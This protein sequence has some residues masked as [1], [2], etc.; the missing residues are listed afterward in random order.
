MLHPPDHAPG[1]LVCF[2]W[3][4]LF[5]VAGNVRMKCACSTDRDIGFGPSVADERHQPRSMEQE[6]KDFH[7]PPPPITK[8]GT[9]EDA[10]ALS[11]LDGNFILVRPDEQGMTQSTAGTTLVRA[12]PPKT[13][14]GR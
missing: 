10:A 4:S 14:D 6:E 12:P 13:Y 9:T 7:P 1:T 11:S 5:Y 2:V 3:W 8:S